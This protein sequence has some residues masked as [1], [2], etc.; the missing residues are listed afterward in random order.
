ML[1]LEHS[2]HRSNQGIG[3]ICKI[4]L[5]VKEVH[6]GQERRLSEGH[7]D[8]GGRVTKGHLAEAY[9][10]TNPE[11]FPSPL[12]FRFKSHAD[13]SNTTRIGGEGVKASEAT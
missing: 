2:R 6:V 12:V 5:S 4:A 3:I 10:E 13:G 9:Q 11:L 7:S 8:H 1:Y